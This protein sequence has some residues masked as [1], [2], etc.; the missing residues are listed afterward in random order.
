M[1]VECFSV[2]MRKEPAEV[3]EGVVAVGL[4]D[5]FGGWGLGGGSCMETMRICRCLEVFPCWISR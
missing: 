2:L 5:A 3:D 4:E 1:P